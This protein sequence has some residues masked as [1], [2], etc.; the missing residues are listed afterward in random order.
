MKQG[1]SGNS[2][3]KTQ[4]TFNNYLRGL[5]LQLELESY[6]VSSK[7]ESPETISKETS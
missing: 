5:E 4:K 3:W 7:Y 1:F 6:E 2:F